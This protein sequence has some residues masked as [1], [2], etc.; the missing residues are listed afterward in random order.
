MPGVRR[1]ARI[2]ALQSLYEGDSSGHDPQVVMDRLVQEFDVLDDAAALS[3]KMA[4]LG[5]AEKLEQEAA[6]LR[7]SEPFARELVDGV[8]SRRAEIDHLLGR[9]AP[10]WPVHQLSPVV[11]NI[12]R[13]AIFEILFDNKTPP[14]AAI[15]EAVEIAKAYGTDTASKFVNGVL[16][17]VVRQTSHA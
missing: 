6:Q 12:L 13:I 14:K 15:D 17:S 4:S 10:E 1:R 7:Q 2:I 3:Q 11:R 16:G 5:L 9:Y 8:V